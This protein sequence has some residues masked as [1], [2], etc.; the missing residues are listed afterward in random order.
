MRFLASSFTMLFQLTP[1]IQR[2]TKG[3]DGL[4]TSLD[5]STHAPYTVI[6]IYLLI[7]WRIYFNSRPLYRGRLSP[8]SRFSSVKLFQLTPPIQRATL[9]K[10]RLPLIII[11]QLTPPI[12]RA[13]CRAMPN[14]SVMLFQL[15]PPIQRA[16]LTFHQ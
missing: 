5:I 16:T 8:V 1:P 15:T 7:K 3:I 14:G 12:Q 11:F 13:T 9:T 2:A 4:P 10:I 6:N